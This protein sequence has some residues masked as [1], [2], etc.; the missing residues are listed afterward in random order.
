VQP[1]EVDG[2]LEAAGGLLER[3]LADLA[4]DPCP[5]DRDWTRAGAEAGDDGRDGGVVEQG[6]GGDA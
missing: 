1:L 4:V 3:E 2:V 5:V 6:A